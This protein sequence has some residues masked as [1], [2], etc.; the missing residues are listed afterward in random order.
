MEN[1]I[2]NLGPLVIIVFIAIGKLLETA[3]KGK[4]EES[5]PQRTPPNRRPYKPRPVSKPSS[6]D[7]DLEDVQERIRRLIMERAGIEVDEPEP[8][9]EVRTY[10]KPPPTQPQ[11]YEP[12]VKEPERP[13]PSTS[14][15]PLP[16]LPSM[17]TI[18]AYAISSRPKRKKSSVNLSKLGLKNKEDLK[19][20]IL[21]REILG[22]PLALRDEDKGERW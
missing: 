1:L 3:F 13:L 8:Q 16:P 17:A 10:P 11:S 7:G 19:R 2:D 20:A 21:L 5:P 14:R 12:V 9:P 18:D 22:P 4:Q 6:D 15:L